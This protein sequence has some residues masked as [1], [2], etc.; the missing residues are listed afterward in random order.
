MNEIKKENEEIKI[1]NGKN[2]KHE[3]VLSYYIKLVV[4]F[5]ILALTFWIG[6]ERGQKNNPNSNLIKIDDA[7]GIKNIKDKSQV[8][9]SLY[10]DV[11]DKL[12]NK[13][14]DA[15]KLTTEELV[16]NSIRGM[17]AAT[18][19]PYTVFMDPEEN[20]EFNSD[21]EGTFEGIG[22]EL[23]I[24]QGILTVISPLKDSPAQKAGLRTGDK[25][26]KVND[27]STADMNIDV[28]V[29][30]IRGKDGTEVKLTIYRADGEE[31]TKDI[32]VKREIIKVE[33]VTFE[34][35]KDNIAYFNVVRFGDD[36]AIKFGQLIG[37]MPKD[38]N[39]VVIDLR[40]NPGGYL[41]V[42]IDMAGFVL[43]S[44]NTVVIEEDKDGK[45]KKFY[46]RGK[47]ELS[48]IKTVV[49]I[50][51]GSASAS[52][53]LAGALK[54]NRENVTL[55]GK[56]SY[57]KGSVQELVNLKGD[58]SVK[59]TVARWLTPKEEQINEKGINPDV[60]VELTEEDYENSRDPQLDK[61]LELLK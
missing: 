45:K 32:V 36:T 46:S 23:G 6:F 48:G 38:I 39:G 19:D 25:I 17:L 60:E 22:A 55:V 34:M 53:I 21:I 10:W 12:K 61:A 42:A 11:F 30:K 4:V 43:P 50:N 3:N 1:V 2:K 9:M 41:D 52:E 24:K 33:S 27:E 44:G 37:K 5:L 16:Y 13:Y 47:G 40:S 35:K 56:K 18:N 29:S 8:D 58:T 14:V 59:I 51:E 54:D 57:G 26:L 49:L 15:E 31:T 28:A 20:K 7:L